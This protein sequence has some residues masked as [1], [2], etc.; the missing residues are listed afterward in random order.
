[1]EGFYFPSLP[2]HPHP[3][4]LPHHLFQFSPL[5]FPLS[6][7]FIPL[8]VGRFRRANVSGGA[9]AKNEFGVL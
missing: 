3:F 6:L 4:H 5:Q 8:E 7:V 9:P 1:M 2:F